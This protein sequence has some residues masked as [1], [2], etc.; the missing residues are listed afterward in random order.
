MNFLQSTHGVEVR[1]DVSVARSTNG[2]WTAEVVKGRLT[3]I[4]RSGF[5]TRLDAVAWT[6]RVSL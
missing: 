6:V 2:T 1:T 5:A 4:A 3:T